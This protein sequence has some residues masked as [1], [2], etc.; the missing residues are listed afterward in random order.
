[1]KIIPEEHGRRKQL[2][3]LVE[4]LDPDAAATAPA[5]HGEGV[6]GEVQLQE[7]V[8]CMFISLH[9][10]NLFYRIS[11]QSMWAVICRRTR[12]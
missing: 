11:W 2:K 1:M 8:L 7:G 5:A 6:R 9:P 3:R 12:T 4:C 10:H